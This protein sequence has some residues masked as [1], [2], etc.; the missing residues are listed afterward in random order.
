[1]TDRIH[2]LVVVLD[3]DIREDDVESVVQAI[4]MI[5]CVADVRTKVADFETY[6]ARAR[7]REDLRERM[8]KLWKDLGEP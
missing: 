4:K 2:A 5:R 6:T 7:V 3:H 1:M 8:Y